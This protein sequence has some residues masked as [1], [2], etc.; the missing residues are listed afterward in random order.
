MKPIT[1]RDRIPAGM[2]PSLLMKQILTH[3]LDEPMSTDRPLP[4]DGYYWC[5]KTCS[6]IGPDDEHVRPDRCVPGRSCHDL[7]A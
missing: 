4:G 3:S 6:C 1:H 2:C 7:K 5:A